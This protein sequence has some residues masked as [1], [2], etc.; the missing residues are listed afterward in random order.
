MGK[1]CPDKTVVKVL[2]SWQECMT[3]LDLNFRIKQEEV[4]SQRD[5][6]GP[7]H[8]QICLHMTTFQC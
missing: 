7:Q 8:T 5:R 4:N 6:C 1:C 2:S 3:G